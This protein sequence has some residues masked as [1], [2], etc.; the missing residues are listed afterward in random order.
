MISSLALL[1][2]LPLT[3]ARPLVSDIL[4]RQAAC[5][6]GVHIIAARGSTEAPGEGKCQS[7]SDLIKAQIPG[8]D[9]VAVVYPAAL[10]E[11]ETSETDGVKNM[12]Q[13]IQS[14]TQS[15]PNTKIVLTG[16]SQGAQVVGDVLGGG[17][18]GSPPTAPLSAQFSQNIMAALQFGDP[19]HVA[20]KPYDKGNGTHNGIFHRS[21]TTA[22][23]VHSAILQSWCL[24]GDLFC[25]EGL[26]LATHGAEIPTNQVPATQFVVQ[27]AQAAGLKTTTTAPSQKKR[28]GVF[29]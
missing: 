24:H 10:L 5:A 7:L 11:Y 25:D 17:S 26:S 22:L 28:S 29:M 1:S 4:P 18:Y 13:M 21:D 27:L 6:T 14:Y 12:T 9:D 3:F 19:A 20:G 23:D 2:L 8:S 16:F 15:C